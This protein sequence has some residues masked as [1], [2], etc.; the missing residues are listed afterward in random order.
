MA[1]LLDGE[2]GS[3][4]PGSSEGVGVVGGELQLVISGANPWRRAVE[5][6]ELVDRV[7]FS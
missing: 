1:A 2:C 3:V 5:R 4:A 7:V 6:G